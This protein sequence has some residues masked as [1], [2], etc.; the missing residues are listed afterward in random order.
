[1]LQSDIDINTCPNRG[2]TMK[3]PKN[4]CIV[5][6]KRHVMDAVPNMHM[7]IVLG[8]F[9]TKVGE[10]SYLYPACGAFTIKHMIQENE[11]KTLHC[12]VTLA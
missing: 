1:M 8:D 10:E 6:W 2:K 11:W 5:L 3:Y 9:N 4:N 12:I 7:K